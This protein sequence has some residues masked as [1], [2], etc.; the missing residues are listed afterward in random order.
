MQILTWDDQ[1][2]QNHQR[3]IIEKA[4]VAKASAINGQLLHI[5]ACDTHTTV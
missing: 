1:R 2:N 3:A 5:A 4:A